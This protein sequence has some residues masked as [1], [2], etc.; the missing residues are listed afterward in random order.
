MSGELASVV[1]APHPEPEPGPEPASAHLL[2]I[3]TPERYLLAERD[4]PPPEPGAEVGVSEAEGRFVVPISAPGSACCSRQ[5]RGPAR[6]SS[7]HLSRR[8]LRTADLQGVRRVRTVGNS[9]A[10]SAHVAAVARPER[11]SARSSRHQKSSYPWNA[12]QTAATSPSAAS[13]GTTSAT[14]TSS[15]NAAAA[16]SGRR[17]MSARRGTEGR[18]TRAGRARRPAERDSGDRVQLLAD[19]GER[20][21]HRERE[22]DDAGDHGQVE[23]GVDVAREGGPLGP[24]DPRAAAAETDREEVEIREPERR[25]TSSPSTAATISPAPR[26]VSLAPTP[27]ATS[28]SPIAMITI[29]PWRSTKCAGRAAAPRRPEQRPEQADRERERARAAA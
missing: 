18:R 25:A 3:P 11:I 14:G 21:L 16:T 10:G 28:D 13:A 9:S 26:R 15:A 7:A 19:V 8:A 23:V 6:S 17:R 27:I 5:S 29:S 1:E 20:R 22:Q 4:G 2:F 12:T 24:P